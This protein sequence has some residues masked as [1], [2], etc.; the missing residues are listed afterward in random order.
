MVLRTVKTVEA[1]CDA[2]SV[3]V[4]VTATCVSA[5]TVSGAVYRPDPSIIPTAGERLQLT[6]GYAIQ[7]IC[8]WKATDS[9]RSDSRTRGDNRHGTQD[10]VE[11]D[12]GGDC[13][14]GGAG[15]PDS[16]RRQIGRAHV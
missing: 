3:L 14:I 10:Q 2:L 6:F 12:S 13:S 1:V 5:D 16:H 9:P 8:D 11:S 15:G 7:L 4:A